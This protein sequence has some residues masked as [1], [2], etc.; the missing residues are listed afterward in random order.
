MISALAF[1]SVLA[2]MPVIPFH[3]KILILDDN[4]FD[5]SRIRRMFESTG[6]SFQ[7]C[8]VEAIDDMAELLEN[9]DFDIVLID[10]RLPVGN[11]FSALDMVQNH[12][13]S[14]DTTTVMITGDDQSW[15]AVSALKNGCKD[16]IAKDDLSVERLR[17]LVLTAIDDAND[18]KAKSKRLKHKLEALSLQIKSSQSGALQPKIARVIQD[19]R[20]LRAR[21][22]QPQ[23]ALAQELAIIEKRC[24]NLWANLMEEDDVAPRQKE[25]DCL[26]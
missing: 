11:G 15:V 9:N 25:L 13:R 24:L 22:Y 7:L 21:V 1:D 17:S 26:N 20:A 16:Y 19:I 6:L 8:E 18:A 4:Q 23:S 3:V 10:Y 14:V 5:R 12:P 2:R